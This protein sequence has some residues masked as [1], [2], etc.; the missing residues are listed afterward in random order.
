VSSEEEDTLDDSNLLMS[1]SVI[2]S[3]DF[4]DSNQSVTDFIPNEKNVRR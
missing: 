3:T 4:Y 1:G 2:E